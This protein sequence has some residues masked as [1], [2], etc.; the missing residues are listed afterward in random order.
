MTSDDLAVMRLREAGFVRPQ[1]LFLVEEPSGIG[2]PPRP[3]PEVPGSAGTVR[4]ML[5]GDG[6][7]LEA[8]LAPSFAGFIRTVWNFS[9]LGVSFSSKF[10]FGIS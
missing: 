10:R 8:F 4:T 2:N 3:D 7:D 1:S 9:R 6:H 5:I